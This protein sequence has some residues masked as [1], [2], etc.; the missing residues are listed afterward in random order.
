MTHTV[1][2]VRRSQ[3][4]I[5]PA[6]ACIPMMAEIAAKFAASP[7]P[8]LKKIGLD[9]QAEHDALILSLDHLGIVEPI[10]A[11]RE[12]RKWISVDGRHRLEWLDGK[13]SKRLKVPLIE[14]SKADAEKIIEASVIGRR[15][16]TKGQ[17]A[18]LGVM[19]HPEVC[20]AAEGRPKNSDS[21]GVSLTAT[22][23]ASRLG[24]SADIVSQAVQLYRLFF[25]PGEKTGSPA[26]IEA[27]ARKVKYEHR[28][29]GGAGLGGVLAGIAGGDA[30]GDKPKA[31]TGFHHLDA[32]LAS[33]SRLGKVFMSWDPEERAK[34]QALIVARVRGGEGAEG[35]PDEFR[36]ALAEALAAAD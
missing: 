27:A 7:K 18:W 29:W 4:S 17:R 9:L 12:G 3:V 10:K 34:A 16:W 6:L 30:T 19:Q 26:A 2:L 1:H 35:W 22:S 28:I 33:L 36:Q 21:V 8:E 25:A 20:E 11:Y 15:H 31:P 23:L 24:V 14:I 13:T 5:A 32:P